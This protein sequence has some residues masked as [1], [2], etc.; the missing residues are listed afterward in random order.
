MAFSGYLH[1]FEADV[2]FRKGQLVGMA[3]EFESSR[4]YSVE[5]QFQ[6]GQI[7]KQVVQDVSL[8]K[9]KKQS[10]CSSLGCHG[11]AEILKH[12]N[13][14]DFNNTFVLGAAHTFLFGVAK[15]FL[16]LLLGRVPHDRADGGSC[17]FKLLPAS[18]KEVSSRC[19][20][21]IWKLD[22]DFGRQFFDLTGKTR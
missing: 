15:N 10:I 8:S 5:E 22:N 19:Q 11:P 13:Y 21:S 14:A 7:A 18:M 6:R 17:A 12:L 20:P 9:A 16:R 4:P 1:P 3:W 2:G